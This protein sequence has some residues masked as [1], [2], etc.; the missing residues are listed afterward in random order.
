MNVCAAF[1]KASNT[2]KIIFGTTHGG[3][4]DIYLMNPDGSEQVNITNN[5]TDD[6]S[7][8]WSQRQADPF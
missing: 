6:V 2:A 7:G 1:A 5:R 4:R 8:V 3:N